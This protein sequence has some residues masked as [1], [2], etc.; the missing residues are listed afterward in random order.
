MKADIYREKK[1]FQGTL[2]FLQFTVHS[3][4]RGNLFMH[5]YFREAKYNVFTESK[6]CLLLFSNRKLFFALISM[7]S[8]VMN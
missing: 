2:H 6:D 7:D 3:N 4:N 1:H 5:F 8:T